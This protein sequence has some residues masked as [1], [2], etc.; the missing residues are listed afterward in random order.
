MQCDALSLVICQLK[1]IGFYLGQDK[2]DKEGAD[3]IEIGKLKDWGSYQ[4]GG[5]HPDIYNSVIYI[6]S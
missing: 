2:A 5:G 4:K 6:F 1:K 3:L